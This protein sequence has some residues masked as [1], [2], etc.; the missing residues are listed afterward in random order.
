[1]GVLITNDSLGIPNQAKIFSLRNFT[2]T[3]TSLA[4]EEMASTHVET[5]STTK[6]MY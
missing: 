4:L 1:M 5:Q 6:K 2:T 3:L